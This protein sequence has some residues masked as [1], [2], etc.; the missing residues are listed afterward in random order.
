MIE[1]EDFS[2]NISM[3]TI[4]YLYQCTANGGDAPYENRHEM[5]FI[6]IR[7]MYDQTGKVETNNIISLHWSV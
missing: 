6:H 3:V 2:K 5:I 7:E 1:I 4:S